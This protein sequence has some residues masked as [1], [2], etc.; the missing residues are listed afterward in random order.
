MGGILFA[1]PRRKRKLSRP[2]LPTPIRIPVQ[3]SP[4]DI[5]Y[6]DLATQHG[7]LISVIH[8]RLY[9]SQGNHVLFAHVV[10]YNV[11]FLFIL[12]RTHRR[13]KELGGSGTL[14]TLLF[15][16]ATRAG[17]KGSLKYP[18]EL[19]MDIRDVFT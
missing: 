8:E 15:L 9:T 5:S 2:G 1:R 7:Y 14:K 16:E 13:R 12:S 17:R 4:Y 11:L 18:A 10:S 6:H 3:A 19:A